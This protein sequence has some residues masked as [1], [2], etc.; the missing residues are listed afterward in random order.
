MLAHLRA[1]AYDSASKFSTLVELTRKDFVVGG[2]GYASWNELLRAVDVEAPPAS[3]ICASV[4]LDLAVP[5]CA[6]AVSAACL[7]TAS[8]R[9]CTRRPRAHTDR[10]RRR[11]LR[12]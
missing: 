9:A 4:P 3:R 7:S 11:W 12:Q 5:P 10:R 6:T 2:G 1:I 8:P